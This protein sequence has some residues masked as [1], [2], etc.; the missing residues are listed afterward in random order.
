MIKRNNKKGF[1]IVELVIVIA[2]IAIL[3]AVL[4]PTFAGIIK[5]ANLSADEQA[6]RQMNTII[7]AEYADGAKAASFTDVCKALSNNNL[8]PEGYSP[9]T[10]KHAFYWD[11]ENNQVLLWSIEDNAVVAPNGYEDVTAVSDK[12]VQ[13]K[14]SAK[15]LVE[16][17]ATAAGAKI[18]V[19][20]PIYAEVLQAG[21]PAGIV[22][23]E[24]EAVLNLGEYVH[25]VDIDNEANNGTCVSAIVVNKE[26]AKLTIEDVDLE[27]NGYGVYV[28]NGGELNITGGTYKANTTAIQVYEG[29]LNISGGHFEVSQKDPK[30]LINAIDSAW[31]AGTA[32]ISI[33]GGT[34][35]N[36]D[37]SAKWE[38]TDGSYVADGYKVVAENQANGDVWYTVVAE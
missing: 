36:F 34:F 22:I 25:T 15:A 10:A 24:G 30:Y 14:D 21:Q 19:K 28:L 3:A 17:V 12:W 16:Q 32:K 18:E 4:I 27:T 26:G 9:L 13:F 38:S 1:T 31:N 20:E 2:V 29:T 6:V 11:S 23:S 5:K 8:M 37:P 35:V 33:T 7:A